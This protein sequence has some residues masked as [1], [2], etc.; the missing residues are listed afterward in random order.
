[1]LRIFMRTPV[2]QPVPPVA[3]FGCEA[4]VWRTN[5]QRGGGGAEIDIM[6]ARVI[7]VL[8]IAAKGCE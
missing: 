6:F 1:V 5:C 8:S 4:Q 2:F 7:F 3:A